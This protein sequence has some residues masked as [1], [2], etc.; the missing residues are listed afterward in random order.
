[1]RTTTRRQFIADLGAIS[2]G[3][4]IVA[5]LSFSGGSAGR[6]LLPGGLAAEEADPASRPFYRAARYYEKLDG[7]RVRCLVCPR[8]CVVGD[9]ERGYCD[10]RENVGGKYYT[11]VYGRVCTYNVDPIEKKP[12]FHFLPGKQAFSLATVGCNLDCKFCQNWEISQ[13]KPENMPASDMPP[14]KVVE[15]AERLKAPVV[16]YTYTEP[17]VYYEF[18]LDTARAGKAKGL[19]NVMISGGYINAEPLLALAREMDAIKIDLKGFTPEFY[20]ETCNA[21]LAPVLE[22]ITAVKKAGTWLE[23]VCLMIPTLNDGEREID[24][25]AKWLVANVGAEVPVHFT[26]FYPTYKLAN[27]P[28][29]PV[30][31]VERARQIAMARGLKYVYVGN[32]PAKNPGESTYC[33]KCGDRVIERAGFTVLGSKLHDGRCVTCNSPIPG[34]WS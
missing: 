23:I 33:P 8:K 5:G 26:R 9:G 27:L 19:R 10:V 14:A 21:T 18:M 6:M 11:M 25:M 30:A 20:A 15:A 17:T 16:A 7:L 3:V 32:V 24:A 29:T 22:T 4:P 13:E 1:M 28:P 34:V 2:V 12:F 31:T